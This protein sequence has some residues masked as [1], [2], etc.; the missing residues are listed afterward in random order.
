MTRIVLKSSA[1]TGH[2]PEYREPKPAD[3][4][5]IGSGCSSTDPIWWGGTGTVNGMTFHARLA[6]DADAGYSCV[7]ST[8]P[9]SSMIW[10]RDNAAVPV[11]AWD[12]AGDYALLFIGDNPDNN[13]QNRFDVWME[14]VTKMWERGGE[15]ILWSPYTYYLDE[16]AAQLAQ[17]RKHMAVHEAWMDYANERRPNG[18]KRV[19]ICPATLAFQ[20]IHND[21]EAGETPS[22]DLFLEPQ[23][24]KTGQF[25]KDLCRYREDGSLDNIHVRAEGGYLC[26][27][28]AASYIWG[29]DPMAASNQWTNTES[30]NAEVANYLKRKASDAIKGYPRAG[31]DTSGWL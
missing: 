13:T 11:N 24:P 29:F 20:A 15:C 14:W 8:I 27:L 1:S 2:V 6:M 3:A 7:K 31:V 21:T 28:M 10:R 4:T 22:S 18:A 17:T 30:I 25:A 9:G 16:P 26:R 23:F 19:R 5:V 12:V